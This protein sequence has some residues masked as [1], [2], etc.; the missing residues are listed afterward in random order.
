MQRFADRVVLVTGAST[1]IGLETIRRIA[2]EGGRVYAG[3]RRGD[4]DLRPAVPIHLDVTSESDW[5]RA[6]A[7]VLEREGRLD[8]LV[9]NAGLRE[10]GPV[11]ETTLGQWHRLI[12]ANLTSTFLGCRAAVPAIRR[13][14]GGAIVNVGSITGIRGTEAMVAYSASKSGIVAMTASLALDLARDNIRVN[15]V[16]PAAIRTRMVTDWLAQAE[17]VGAA[18]EAVRR[19]HPIG[20][21]GRPEE[22][23][24]VIAFL[25]SD[26]ASFMTG[27]AIPVDGGRSIR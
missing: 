23:A 13:S 5:G 26:D 22:V 11:E 17:D 16:C 7:V 12:D 6:I 27:L 1:G 3:H 4:V 8:V 19:K 20:R 21:I 15:A 14:G 2:A 24:S 25:A 10:S 18:E 9:N